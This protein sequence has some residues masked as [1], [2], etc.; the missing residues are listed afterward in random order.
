MIHILCAIAMP[1]SYYIPTTQSISLP[2]I[3]YWKHMYAAYISFKCQ[4]DYDVIKLLW[5]ILWFGIWE[6]NNHMKKIGNY[7][8]TVVVFSY[9]WIIPVRKG[10]KTLTFYLLIY[11]SSFY[12]C[13]VSLYWIPEL[14]TIDWITVLLVVY[15]TKT[16]SL[17]VFFFLFL[18]P[19]TKKKT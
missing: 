12:L 18:Y 17:F 3:F 9:Q 10:K 4:Y 15:R 5:I 2:Y 8:H 6:T 16:K 14:L 19:N 11:I 7:M 13:A 1:C